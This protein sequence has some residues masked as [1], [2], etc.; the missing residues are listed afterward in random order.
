MKSKFQVL[1]FFAFALWPLTAGAQPLFH[2][3]HDWTIDVNGRTYGIR[4]V[5]QTP[6]GFRRT[7]LF[8]AG[9]ALEPPP[10]FLRR[11]RAIARAA[12]RGR[13]RNLPIRPVPESPDEPY[14]MM[15]GWRVPS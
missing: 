15:E 11:D 2:W 1:W 3:E 9:H 5:V 7:Q 6:G 10:A 8:V 13:F 4:E 14:M 12:G